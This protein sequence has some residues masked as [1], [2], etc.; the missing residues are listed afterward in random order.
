R[1]SAELAC[2][3]GLAKREYFRP[4]LYCN[5]DCLVLYGHN[6][7][8]EPDFVAITSRRCD[9][10][11]Y[12]DRSLATTVFSVPVHVSTI[13]TVSLDAELLDALVAFRKQASNDE[14]S[15]WQN[16]IACFNQANTDNPAFRYQVEWVLLCSAFQR[17]LRAGSDARDVAQKF[18]DTIVPCTTLEVRQ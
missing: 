6:F 2:F 14:W 18:A 16:A 8:Q 5:T 7:S 9:G 1:E 15:R 17:I 13:E 11:I 12:I 10:R 3:C 4:G